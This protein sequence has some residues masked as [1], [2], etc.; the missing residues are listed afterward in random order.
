MSP[1]QLDSATASVRRS[2]TQSALALDEATP[3]PVL[4]RRVRFLLHASFLLAVLLALGLARIQS[5][6]WSSGDTAVRSESE[7]TEWR[8]PSV[9]QDTAAVGSG[10]FG[11][12]LASRLTPLSLLTQ[13]L[14]DGHLV[15][16][17]TVI[18]LTKPAEAR[19]SILT[20]TIAPGDNVEL[21]AQKFGLLPTTIVW[22]NPEIE[23][24]PDLLRVGQVL[25]ILPV[26]GILYEVK[27]DDTLS[28]IAQRFK[29]KPEEIVNF[30]LNNLA[31]GM[32]LVPGQRLVIPGGV[33]PIVVRTRPV[34]QT[35]RAA[36][37]GQRYVGPAPSFV[38]T[39]A[40]IWPTRGYLSQGYW[41][42][43]R[44]I[45][46][47]NA[48]GTPIAAADG[49]YVTFAGWSPVGY[50]Y[51]VTIDHGNGFVTLYAH[52]SQWY[53]SPG[54]AVARGQIIGAMGS[55]GRSTGPHLHF[56]IRYGGDLLNPRIYLP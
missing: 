24:S 5:A 41:W 33:K 8:S 19:K 25:N 30:P 43:H 23:E 39:G 21:I 13:G 36:P 26:D 3:L 54:Q 40:F 28:G 1:K 46:I 45:D 44:G 16:R 17:D 2:S 20:Y 15:V 6:L 12:R 18:N 48:T 52:L 4:N 34:Q 51:M 9:V 56:E 31:Q 29:V 14:S 47:A 32:N 38:A 49:G 27:P 55:T 50:G 22:S 7:S 11:G 53:V 42:G 35:Q 37:P 10:R